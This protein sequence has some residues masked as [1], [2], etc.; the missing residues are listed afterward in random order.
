L[1]ER[2]TLNT[3]NEK[4]YEIWLQ[5]KNEKMK[6]WRKEDRLKDDIKKKVHECLSPDATILPLKYTN[7]P[8]TS[9]W[10]VFHSKP[11]KENNMANNPA[12]KKQKKKQHL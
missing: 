3:R 6:K 5:R 1:D 7:R 9:T 10:M 8:R 12:D 4:W 11:D 2:A